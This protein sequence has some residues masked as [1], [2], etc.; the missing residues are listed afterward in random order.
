M[1]LLLIEDE[2]KLAEALAQI[3]KKHGYETDISYDGEEGLDNALSGIYDV[4]ILDRMLPL[5]NGID[6]LKNIRGEGIGTPVIF[7]TAIDGISERVT[8]LDAVS[9]QRFGFCHRHSN[10]FVLPGVGAQVIAA[11]K[12]VVKGKPLPRR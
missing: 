6:V 4:I 8:G 2:C 3:L 1:R 9:N 11:D 10:R 7:L 5:M 12:D